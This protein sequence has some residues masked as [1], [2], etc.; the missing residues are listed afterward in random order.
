ML[1][2]LP[3]KYN[4]EEARITPRVIKWF[5][6]NYSKSCVLEIKVGKN[7]ILPHQK[8]ALQQVQ[9]GS[10][11]WKI[12]DTGT[13]NPFDSFILK[14]ADAF[15]VICTGFKCQVFPFDEATKPFFIEI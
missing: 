4:R 5:V 12:P 11:S 13:K 15:L 10:F 3:K 14:N 8:I 6:E 9:G 2:N 1:P 7:K